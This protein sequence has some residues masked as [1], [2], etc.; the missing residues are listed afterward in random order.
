MDT[1]PARTSQKIAESKERT[2]GGYANLRE[3]VVNDI[4][5]MLPTPVV[6]DM[7][8]NKTPEVWDEWT[9]KTREKHKNGNG[10]GPRINIEMLRLLAEDKENDVSVSDTNN[11]GL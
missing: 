8:A 2:P 4:P 9:A 6:N 10:H 7:G 11:E 5:V 3:T 1:L